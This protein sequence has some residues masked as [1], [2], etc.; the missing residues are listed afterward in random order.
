MCQL[1]A[2][3]FVQHTVQIWPNQSDEDCFASHAWFMY[4]Y[5]ES[6]SCVTKAWICP[7]LFGFIQKKITGRALSPVTMPKTG[8]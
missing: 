7:F 2:S 1:F 3:Y 5:F 4:M 8:H 6:V